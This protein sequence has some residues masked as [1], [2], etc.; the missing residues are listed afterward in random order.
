MDFREYIPNEE[1]VAFY[2][3]GIKPFHKLS[4]FALIKDGIKFNKLLFYS[5]EHAFQAQKYIKEQRIRFSVE[6]D[7]GNVDSGFALVFGG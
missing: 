4:N 3:C 1:V 6:G 7:L 2:S 5:T